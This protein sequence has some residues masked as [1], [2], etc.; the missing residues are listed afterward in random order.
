MDSARDFCSSVNM[1]QDGDKIVCLDAKLNNCEFS[2]GENCVE[3]VIGE[4]N[5]QNNGWVICDD[6]DVSRT[7]EFSGIPLYV[8]MSI[9]IHNP[10]ILFRK[11]TIFEV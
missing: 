9:D 8:Q 11:I 10:R 4:S 1:D 7:Q 3:M 2:E 5:S 6:G